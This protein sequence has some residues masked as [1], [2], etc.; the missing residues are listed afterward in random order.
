M[1]NLPNSDVL[2]ISITGIASSGNELI[3]SLPDGYEAESWQWYSDGVAI[4]GA[5][6]NGYTVLE[7]DLGSTLSVKAINIYKVATGQIV[8]VRTLSKFIVIESFD[9][10]NNMTIPSSGSLSIVS[11]GV[12]EGTNA[13][14]LK[15]NGTSNT[16]VRT[17]ITFDSTVDVSDIDTISIAVTKNIPFVNTNFA[18]QM[19][20]DMSTFA[21]FTT[22]TTYYGFGVNTIVGR[23]QWLNWNVSEDA[24]VNGVMTTLQGMRIREYNSVAPYYENLIFDFLVVNGKGRPTVVIGFDDGENTQATIAEPYMTSKGMVGT[25][26]L[27]TQMV[28]L[29]DSM[30]WSE[31]NQIKDAGWA[32]CIDGMP[33]DTKMTDQATVADAVA[34]CISQWDDLTAQGLDSD[35]MYHLCYP[36]GL[37]YG[38]EVASEMYV[39]IG[40]LTTDGTTTATLDTTYTIGDG[41]T[42]YGAGLDDITVA[43]GGTDVSNIIL[44]ESVAAQSLPAMAVNTNHEF[45]FDKLPQALKDAGIK[46]GRITGGGSYFSRFG[47][48]SELGALTTLGQ[49]CS[50][51]SLNEVKP[52]VDQAILRGNTLEFYIHRIMDDPDGWTE[53]TAN[54]GI[55]VYESFFKGLVDYI[56]EK[57]D[58]GELDVLTKPQLYDRDVNGSS[59]LNA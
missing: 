27:P 15:G 14:E 25:S 2:P 47:F 46:S 10:I 20:E 43:T 48:G 39:V 34:A 32:I 26:Y 52:F 6:S 9:D 19:S 55:N 42:L 13:I 11:S 29:S 4:F 16:A 33:D 50:G 30:D 45:Y 41:W 36:N 37:H 59:T 22:D 21:G 8:T 40:T 17:D 35:D 31:V 58:S 23:P 56:A 12:V 53:D 57:R 1:R 49:G 51:M 18:F 7:T 3:A 54:S 24:N 38:S 44:S 28:G 5:T